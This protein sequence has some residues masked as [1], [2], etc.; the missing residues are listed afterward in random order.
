[1]GGGIK[2]LNSGGGRG[3]DLWEARYGHVAAIVNSIMSL[4]FRKMRKFL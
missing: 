3:L 4:G 2:I 1:V